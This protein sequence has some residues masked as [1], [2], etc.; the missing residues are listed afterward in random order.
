MNYCLVIF[1]QVQTDGWTDGQTESDAY[2]PTVQSAQVGSKSE[3]KTVVRYQSLVMLSVPHGLYKS[4]LRPWCLFDMTQGQKKKSGA[5]TIVRYQFFLL[6]SN[7]LSRARGAGSPVNR[8]TCNLIHV[9]GLTG[10]Q[11]IKIVQIP[12]LF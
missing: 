5:K 12:D 1:G 9:Y 4:F 10:Y 2:E 3:A 7:I 8:N 6:L 11:K